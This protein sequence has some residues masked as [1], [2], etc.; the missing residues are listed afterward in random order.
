[1]VSLACI[2]VY[3]AFTLSVTAWRTKFRVQMNAA[4]QEAGNRAID[5]LIN[6]ETVKV[7]SSFIWLW[8]WCWCGVSL[9]IPS[10]ASITIFR[11]VVRY[12]VT[13]YRL[14]VLVCQWHKVARDCCIVQS[15]VYSFFSHIFIGIL[16]AFL[17]KWYFS[18]YTVGLGLK[19]ACS[20]SMVG[21]W[22]TYPIVCH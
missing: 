16:I 5:S 19:L 2:S 21:G 15:S 22:C 1:M 11:Y 3:A 18:K 20:Y 14:M 13:A 8:S 4:D 9:W 17:V 6:Y 10:L 7:T 12:L